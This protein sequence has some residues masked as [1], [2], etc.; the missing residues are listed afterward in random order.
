MSKVKTGYLTG[1][2]HREEAWRRRTD[3]ELANLYKEAK[4][5][6]VARR[7][8]QMAGICRY[9]VWK[10]NA[11]NDIKQGSWSEKKGKARPRNRWFES[12]QYDLQRKNVMH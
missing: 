8:I 12:F 7:T 2:I 5:T 10:Q 1:G 6:A 9:R 11:Q 4:I 3:K